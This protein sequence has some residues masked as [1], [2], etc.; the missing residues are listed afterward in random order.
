V[1]QQSRKRLTAATPSSTSLRFDESAQAHAGSS[2]NSTNP[3]PGVREEAARKDLQLPRAAGH[4]LLRGGAPCPVP[5]ATG[6]QSAGS[7]RSLQRSAHL[8][9]GDG[10]A[11]A[12]AAEASCSW[13]GVSSRLTFI[14]PISAAFTL[15]KIH[16]LD[17]HDFDRVIV[18][19]NR[20]PAAQRR[21]RQQ[22]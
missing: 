2:S 10:N 9:T 20:G 17:L 14:R 4:R 7:A 3:P 13:S 11:P 1:L 6:C 15:H 5:P 19:L 21:R 22:H 12:P 8:A 16:N 18:L